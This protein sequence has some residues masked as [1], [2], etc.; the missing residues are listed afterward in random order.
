MATRMNHR[1][2]VTVEI[3][4]ETVSQLLCVPKVYRDESYATELAK[5]QEMPAMQEEDAR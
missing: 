5:T 3:P 2:R 4:V 1:K